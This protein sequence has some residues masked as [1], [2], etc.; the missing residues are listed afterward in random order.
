MVDGGAAKWAIIMI[1]TYIGWFYILN[2]ISYS[3]IINGY[4][5]QINKWLING[6]GLWKGKV[7]RLMDEVESLFTQHFANSDRKKAM[8][9]LRPQQQKDSHVVTF[10]V[11]E[12]NYYYY[13][14]IIRLLV[15]LINFHH[16]NS[17]F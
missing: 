13:L 7:V 11:G 1:S 17:R 10:F 4:V 16:I 2:I 9:F 8:K 12:F 6:V 5:I 3:G 14:Y 15:Y